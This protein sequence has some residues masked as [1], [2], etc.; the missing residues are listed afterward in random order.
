VPGKKVG[1]DI[2]DFAALFGQAHT[3][4]PAVDFAALV[5]HITHIDQLFDVGYLGRVV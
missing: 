3:H 4:R 1:H 5:M 2:A